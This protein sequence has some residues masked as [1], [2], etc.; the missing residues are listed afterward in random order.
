MEAT[1]YMPLLDEG[2]EVFRPVRASRDGA[3]F[4]ILGPMPDEETW[5]F[6]P[7]NRVLCVSREFPDGNHLIA[8]RLAAAPR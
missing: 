5:K 7:G 1:I 3:V 8:T 4:T 2:T 6:P